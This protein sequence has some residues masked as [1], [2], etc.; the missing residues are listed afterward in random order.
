MAEHTD[1]E[2][3]EPPDPFEQTEES[4]KKVERLNKDLNLTALG[5]VFAA[6]RDAAMSLDPEAAQRKIRANEPLVDF[7]TALKIAEPQIG[8]SPR[9]LVQASE[10]QNIPLQD[11]FTRITQN[12][13]PVRSVVDSFESKRTQVGRTA[14]QRKVKRRQAGIALRGIQRIETGEK[15]LDPKVKKQTLTKL[16]SVLELQ[17]DKPRFFT[18]DADLGEAE[19]AIVRV[20]QP[21]FNRIKKQSELLHNPKIAEDPK[22]AQLLQDM[23]LDL[24]PPTTGAMV[25]EAIADD[26]L[27]KLL[28]TLTTYDLNKAVREQGIK[29]GTTEFEEAKSKF[30]KDNLYQATLLKAS[31]KFF[32]PMFISY[33]MIDP[34]QKFPDPSSDEDTSW[35][36]KMIDAG[37]DVRVEVVGLDG[38]GSPVYRFTHPTWH[39][40]E[41]ADSVQAGV[42]GVVERM[43]RGI[44]D[45]S[46]LEMIK[47]GS[48]EGV[49]NRRDLLKAALST[50][51]AGNSTLGAAAASLGGFGSAVLFPDLFMGAAAAARA[52][53]RVV[54][55]AQSVRAFKAIAPT[56]I[57][58]LGDSAERL[59]KAEQIIGDGVAEAINA[60]NYDEALRLL[61]EAKKVAKE[62]DASISRAREASS[63]MVRVVDRLDQ[64][65]ASSRLADEIPEMMPVEGRRVAAQIPG[66]FGAT[67]E[68]LHPSVRRVELRGTQEDQIAPF[69]ELLQ[70]ERT[71]NHLQDSIRLLQK[72]DINEQFL[73]QYVDVSNEFVGKIRG[74]MSDAKVGT[75]AA[76]L[77]SEQRQASMDLISFLT[78]FNSSRLLRDNPEQ[79]SSTVKKLVDDL[80]FD[81]EDLAVRPKFLREL[82]PLLR[83]TV[84]AASEVK[85]K[86]STKVSI[87]DAAKATARGA[88][89]LRGQ[90]E[91]RAAAMAFV[92]EN[93][94][95]AA[96][97]EVNPLL[98]P[99]TEK[100]KAV[101]REGLSPE[102]LSFLRQI[103]LAVPGLKGDEALR[104]VKI[105]D[106]KA[107]NFARV[108]NSTVAN[109]YNEQFRLADVIETPSSAAKTSPKGA[110]GPD[111]E[112]APKPSQSVTD[113]VEEGRLESGL[114]I[115]LDQEGLT[116]GRTIN[117]QIADPGG[118][119][120]ATPAPAVV[121]NSIELPED[122]RNTGLGT[123][124]YL[125]ALD[126][127]KNRGL[128]FLSGLGPS[129]DAMRVY[130]ALERL[131][132]NV[133]R[134]GV[135]VGD[136]ILDQ[137]E[138]TIEDLRKFDLQKALDE[139]VEG[140]RAADMPKFN[141]ESNPVVVERLDDG[142][143][144]LRALTENVTADDFIRALGSASR[145]NLDET[146]MKALVAWLSSKGV[147]VGH[148][149]AV[150]TA[151]DATVIERAEDEFAT[152]YLAYIRSGRSDTPE[153]KS[154]LNK[155]TEW[156]KDTY[157]AA[158]GSAV[159]GPPEG[160]DPDLVKALDKMLRRPSDKVAL[161]NI[162]KITKDALFSPKIIG[163]EIDV[164]QEIMRMTRRMGYPMSATDLNSQMIKAAKLYDQGKK[165][166]AIIRLPGPL[167]FGGRPPKDEY[168]LD[169]I[170]TI[171]RDLESAKLLDMSDTSGIPLGGAHRA[172]GER[173]AAE[174]VDQ[175]VYGSRAA[176]VF[177]NLYLGGDAY[178]DMRGLPL[179]V[180]EAI[181]GG[182]RK[183]QQ[184]IGE[185]ITLVAEKDVTNLMHYL[186]GK[187]TV[188]FAKGGRSAVSAGHDAMGD[189][190][191][192]VRKYFDSIASSSDGEAKL[193]MLED[194]CFLARQRG[195][196]VEA[197]REMEKRGFNQEDL[198]NAFSEVVRGPKANRFLRE[199]FQSAGFKANDEARLLP[200]YFTMARSGDRAFQDPGGLLEIFLYYAGRSTREVDGKPQ[201]FGE[202][203][204]LAG[205]TAER[206]ETTFLRLYNDLNVVFKDD[207][208]VANRVAILIAAH[209]HAHKA[210]LEWVGM[211]IAADQKLRQS[212]SRYFIGEF[213]EPDQLAQVKRFFENVG[214]NPMLV[215]AFDLYGQKMFI[216]A[217]AR[218]RLSMALDQA[219]DPALRTTGGDDLLDVLSAPEDIIRRGAAGTDKERTAK[220][221][222]ALAY[223]YLKTRMVRGHYLLK[224]KYFWMN[225]FDHFNQTA[226]RAGYRTAFISTT[227][228]VS[229]NL[230]SN[231]IGQAFVAAARMSGRGGNVE[232]V[233]RV[234]QNFG[235][236][237]AKWA[238]TLS[239]GSKWHVSVNDVLRG[240]DK[241]IIIGGKPYR[242]NDLRQQFLEA[243]IFASFDT[244]QLGTKIQNVGNLF[245]DEAVKSTTGQTRQIFKNIKDDVKGA[246]E[247]IAE[248]WSERERLGL[249]ITLMETGLD[250]RT[251][252]RVTIDALYDYAGSMSKGDRNFLVNLFFPFWAFQKNANRQLFD[253]IFSPEG[254][255]RLGV[256]RRAHDKGTDVLS[257]L[258]YAAAV[259]EN[260]IAT[261]ALPP[262]LKDTY[263]ALKKQ[264]YER[265][266]VDG[267]IPP[268]ARH[269]LRMFIAGSTF[270][271]H[272]PQL[273]VSTSP[274]RE[275]I[276]A[277]AEDLRDPVTGEKRPINRRLLASFYVP[278]TDRSSL[279]GYYRN[280][281]SARFPY[282]PAAEE[283]I[284]RDPDIP[285]EY[286]NTM[287]TW[288]DLYRTRNPDVP[289]T[290]LFLPESTYVAGMNHMVYLTSSMLMTIQKLEDIGD[291]WWTDEDDGSDAINPYN[292]LIALAQP[293]R[294]PILSDL[295]A[296]LGVGG[297][298]VPRKVSPSLV[299]L[300]EYLGMDVLD[301]DEKDDPF[302]VLN[303][304]QRARDTGEDFEPP[305]VGPET[306]IDPNRNYYLMPGIAQ[307]A[308]VNSPIGEVNEL[309]MRL[310][311]TAPEKAAGLR[312]DLQLAIRALT[313]LEV[314][315]VSRSKSATQEMFRA[316]KETSADRIKAAQSREKLK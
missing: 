78:D 156:V 66:A 103:E 298:T 119:T 302:D 282:I 130:G 266:S 193:T 84:S 64:D 143:V 184:A 172:V 47:E 177:R 215:E 33:D 3:T 121:V 58:E 57:D 173:T 2:T 192:S 165:D 174:M 99:L 293:E 249:A 6:E 213:V 295:M 183:V 160:M 272:G 263:F 194:F 278:R 67:A 131:G 312:G 104:I 202:Q 40:F 297:N 239:R 7:E 227:R 23:L 292:G 43:S 107:R 46:V 169:E 310:Q 118:R 50:E 100:H 301:I 122:L 86:L 288:I 14:G 5:L 80:P 116:S 290:G 62:S 15:K 236:E 170:I 205:M 270:A 110:V 151:S 267:K 134:R 188:Q 52:A 83:A 303:Q 265:L 226:L 277:I 161:P 81:P 27:N 203:V 230:L 316:R 4:K 247:D 19:D 93:V 289:Y 212:V 20:G 147:K 211:G 269:E 157:A 180:R 305:L 51:L 252:A 125:S 189:V 29:R 281:I 127:A 204:K 73:I 133:Q 114:S 34:L 262:D 146:D 243:G 17:K 148:E 309:L 32:P 201:T 294:A 68:N 11:M 206:S 218:K 200:E 72:G 190:I 88:T 153:I 124:L 117:I 225:T 59:A 186:T 48:L 187:A 56:L 232:D 45:E 197:I 13:E 92:R 164:G 91:S 159:G 315:D 108:N 90:F 82:E 223:R 176:S 185:T 98:V 54:T 139:V 120:M 31:N 283:E 28:G 9:E 210:K 123:Q 112:T 41:M 304:M 255:Y 229:Q 195:S 24:G 240:G 271:Y 238:K 136:E 198:M 106:Q 145:R 155:A 300:F 135:R 1:T 285:Q 18:G 8:L 250:P 284:V 306:R 69:P 21:G 286:K 216:P 280:R 26:A 87:A 140:K 179:I 279:P 257:E 101:G 311:K 182:A 251:A 129:P 71:I 222:A 275:E 65:I 261:D 109:Y 178:A 307:A 291:K 154:P 299:M 162:F 85:S 16:R 276:E 260:G 196:S 60:G 163:T 245:V 61:E 35:V 150:F 233:R 287:K 181:Q 144:F 259:D 166:K 149:G 76:D 241:V 237:G 220:M 102:G 207:G 96:K 214:Y 49:R 75:Q 105:E 38:K 44:E 296:S 36:S 219:M 208:Q 53:K 246:S 175:I 152:A 142:R 22:R 113:Y 313:G 79:W 111:P 167:S 132:L 314:R 138:I 158:T 126:Y 228:M 30:F 97:I 89:A 248:A 12:N 268:L 221:Q 25:R 137:F 217:A 39:V 253:T 274:L 10:V 94:A 224:S 168:T 141:V 308:F 199:V 254:A 95:K 37:S 242:A 234:L 70:T 171:Q 258:T 264:V 55:A 115:A 42:S 244:S 273:L 63:D 209:G 74:L 231:N 191:D 235:D 256:M 128:D 77:T